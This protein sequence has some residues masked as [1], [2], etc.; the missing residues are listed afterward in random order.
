MTAPMNPNSAPNT[1]TLRSTVD[2]LTRAA[3]TVAGIW[4]V[5]VGITLVV[6]S[7]NVK[8]LPDL[9]APTPDLQGDARHSGQVKPDARPSA[10]RARS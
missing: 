9:V 10:T 3:L 4:S 2:P 8:R 7:F 6:Q 5:A 1:R